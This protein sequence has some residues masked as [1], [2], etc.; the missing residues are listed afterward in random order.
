MYHRM[1]LRRSSMSSISEE[2][3]MGDDD[4][5]IEHKRLNVENCLGH[6]N[7]F[8]EVNFEMYFPIM[9]F[10]YSR[11]F[12]KLMKTYLHWNDKLE[13][14]QAHHSIL[15]Q[16]PFFSLLLCNTLNK[17]FVFPVKAI[18]YEINLIFIFRK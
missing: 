8:K 15:I 11:K 3:E 4:E 16:V 5:R 13:L 1:Y 9:T 7:N 18:E 17:K 6:L 12:E 10:F 14:K 2:S